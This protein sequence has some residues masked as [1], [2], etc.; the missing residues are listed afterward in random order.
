MSHI[1]LTEEQARI[2]A[3]ST[4]GVE[5]RDPKG[6]VLAYCTPLDREEAE[7]IAES[8][9]RLAQPGPRIP[10]ARVTAMMQTLQ[11]LDDRGEATPEKV[12]EVVRRTKAGEPL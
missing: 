2:L 12:H 9:R 7:I 3:E 11:E 10:G 6:Q 4:N 1:D 5:L 8:K